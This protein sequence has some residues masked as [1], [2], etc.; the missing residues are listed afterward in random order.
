[1]TPHQEKQFELMENQLEQ[2]IANQQENATKLD[3]VLHC[4]KGNDMGQAGLVKEVKDLTIKVET[5]QMERMT[6]KAKS[7]IYLTII[8]WL[9]GTIAALVI[10]GIYNF[11][12]NKLK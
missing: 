12:V 8:K 6:E 1:M 2:V 10:A 11:I 4:L 9:A 7:D 5:I 3:E